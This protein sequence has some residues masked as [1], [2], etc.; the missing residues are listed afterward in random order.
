MKQERPNGFA[1]SIV[2]LIETILVALVASGRLQ[3]TGEEAQL[4]VNVVIAAVI[5]LTP[6]AGFWWAKGM[7]TPLV[8]PLDSDGTALVREDGLMPKMQAAYQVSRKS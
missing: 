8:K 2:T 5:V 3:M 1:G 4:W 6:M 7:Q